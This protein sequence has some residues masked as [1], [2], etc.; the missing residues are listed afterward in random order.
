M[1]EGRERQ[2]SRERY[3]KR[4]WPA[5]ALKRAGM[6]VYPGSLKVTP[7]ATTTTTV[8][9]NKKCLQHHSNSWEDFSKQ[10]LELVMVET[11]DSDRPCNHTTHT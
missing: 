7:V 9:N 5:F 4:K 8:T 6:R 11:H 1:R 2:R 10:S 3:K